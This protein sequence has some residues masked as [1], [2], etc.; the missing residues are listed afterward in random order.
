MED[1][2][3]IHCE[4]TENG[5]VDYIYV[6]VYDGHGG[7]DASNFANQHLLQNIVKQP[8]FSSSQD[9][10]VMEAIRAGFLE[11]HHAMRKVVGK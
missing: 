11:T 4:F 2:I 6:G 1:R 8:G 3:N 5:Q 7:A 10:D 9:S